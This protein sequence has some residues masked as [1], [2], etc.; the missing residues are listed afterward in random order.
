M[1]IMPEFV[2]MTSPSNLFNVVVFSLSSFVSKF[3]FSIITGFGVLTIFVY[4]GLTRNLGIGAFSCNWGLW[5]AR[6]SKFRRNIFNKILLVAKKFHGVSF[7]RFLVIKEKTTVAYNYSPE[8]TLGL[9]K[10][11]EWEAKSGKR[12]YC[13]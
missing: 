4:K 5:R 13:L 1:I 8:R 2:N 12:L 9:I 7:Y 10:F 3:H 11:S 6:D